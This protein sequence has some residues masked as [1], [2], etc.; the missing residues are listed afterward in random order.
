MGAANKIPGV[1]GGMIAFV[2]GFYS[3]FM[4]SLQKINLK[5]IMLLYRKRFKSFFTYINAK[6][7]IPIIVGIAISFFSVSRILDYLIGIYE[8][9]V[10]GYFFGLILG[11]IYYMKIKMTKWRPQ[12]YLFITLGIIS[13]LSL[14]LL[15]KLDNTNMLF[16]FLC[17]MISISG[18]AFP[19]LSGSFILI[20]IGNYILLM[21]DSVNA[22]GS[23]LLD[24]LNFDFEF[25]ND[26]N[27]I[28]L[29][30][31]LLF[32]FLGSVIGMVA[33]SK[34]IGYLLKRFY[35]GLV[36]ILMGFVIGSLAIVWPWKETIYLKNPNGEYELDNYGSKIVSNYSRYIPDTID[37]S[38]ISTLI[39]IIIGL[40]TILL[41]SKYSKK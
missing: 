32:F 36:S 11:S 35:N 30:K 14:L 12:Y 23:T 4:Y 28:Y 10:W 26:S 2:A 24:I 39:L 34:I 25:V 27:R 9:Q 29:L 7:L 17:G 6:F 40:L 22:L 33:F 18:M 38:V 3:E 8:I 31:V 20:I 15:P 37:L 5:A 21:V 41:L 13:G 19:G 1:S 16:I